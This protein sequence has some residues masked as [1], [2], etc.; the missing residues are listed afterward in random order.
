[1]KKLEIERLKDK[2]AQTLSDAQRRTASIEAK[3]ERKKIAIDG[4]AQQFLSTNTY[5][6][7]CFGICK[8]T[9]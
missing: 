8:D 9:D 2:T 1:M 3:R 5:P 6:K 4:Q 7:T